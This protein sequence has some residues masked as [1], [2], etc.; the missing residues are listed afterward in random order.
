MRAELDGIICSGPR[1]GKQFTYALLDE[2]VPP[3]KI[4][5]RQEA[6]AELTNRY[7]TSRGPATLQDFVWWSGLTM[8][9]A[10]EGFALLK[11][12]FLQQV[13]N[14]QNYIFAPGVLENN[15][16]RA[17]QKTFLMPDYDEYGISYKN[18]G[19]LFQPA[20]KNIPVERLSENTYY[21][22]IVIDGVAR[23]TWRRSIK[24]QTIVVETTSFIKLNK[25]KKQAVVKAVK[26]YCSFVGK[27]LRK[28]ILKKGDPQGYRNIHCFI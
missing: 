18:R 6:L 21:H 23:G 4:L 13:I 7:F 8:K 20:G 25:T 22:M 10:K 14:G 15:P 12:N 9:E 16:G 1:Q 24:N 17:I 28:E 26:R 27:V 2:R 3:A 5:E 11:P 19:A